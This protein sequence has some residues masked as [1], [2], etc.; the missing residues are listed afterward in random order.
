[1]KEYN[2]NKESSH[3]MH[4]DASNLWGQAISE[5]LSVDGFQWRIHKPN[6]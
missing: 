5:K 6:F 4:W 1:M 3:L 2:Q